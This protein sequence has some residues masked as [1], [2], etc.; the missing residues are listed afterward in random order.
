MWCYLKIIGPERG[1]PPDLYPLH[2]GISALEIGGGGGVLTTTPST[3]SYSERDR[4]IHVEESSKSDGY[5]QRSLIESTPHGQMLPKHPSMEGIHPLSSFKAPCHPP[6]GAY[7]EIFRRSLT[8]NDRYC[9]GHQQGDIGVVTDRVPDPHQ[10][11][12]PPATRTHCQRKPPTKTNVTINTLRES[13][14][15]SEKPAT[16][17]CSQG[18]HCT[19]EGVRTTMK[20]RL[21]KP[22]ILL[23]KSQMTA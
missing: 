9:I 8:R 5:K 11:H 12:W 4:A 6:R 2:H 10:R 16:T 18:Y 7:P 20:G 14:D 15:H 3:R 1:Q 13:G 22:L 19:Q 21:S 17:Q 23:R